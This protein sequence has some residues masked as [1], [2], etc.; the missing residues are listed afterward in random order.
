MLFSISVCVYT[1]SSCGQVFDGDVIL[2]ING[3]L[4]QDKNHEEVVS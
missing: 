3:E 4:V 1:A 2:A